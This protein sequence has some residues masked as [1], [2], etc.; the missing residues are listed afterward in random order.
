MERYAFRPVSTP[1]APRATLPNSTSTTL[2]TP[3][4]AATHSHQATARTRSP[5]TSFATRMTEKILQRIPIA[6]TL[7]DLD[8]EEN[9]DENM[10][11]EVMDNLT[12]QPFN[13]Q[14]TRSKFKKPYLSLHHL[15]GNTTSIMSSSVNGC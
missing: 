12:P 14:N 1:T 10:E 15:Y 4:T 6:M 5:V 3:G 7:G 9:I 13:D 11:T 8:A 2:V